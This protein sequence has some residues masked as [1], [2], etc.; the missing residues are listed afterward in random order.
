MMKR[1]DNETF[2]KL[3]DAIYKHLCSEKEVTD[4]VLKKLGIEEITVRSSLRLLWISGMKWETITL[5]VAHHY[6][7]TDSLLLSVGNIRVILP[8]GSGFGTLR[9]LL[10]DIQIPGDEVRK[11]KQEE[12]EE[13]YQEV[14]K[15]M[16][17]RKRNKIGTLLVNDYEFKSNDVPPVKMLWYSGTDDKKVVTAVIIWKETRL[18]K[19]TLDT[20]DWMKGFKKGITIEKILSSIDE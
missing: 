4:D 8:N 3:Y 12:F 1:I 5:I 17:T 14:Y 6:T 13:R 15:H 20:G 11:M 9:H 16:L 10:G 18:R 2:G 19:L 7:R